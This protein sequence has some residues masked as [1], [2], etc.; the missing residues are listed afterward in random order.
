MSEDIK[1][2]IT[3][4]NIIIIE[5]KKELNWFREYA[6]YI[7]ENHYTVDAEASSYADEDYEN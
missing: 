7:G 5:L 3:D 6:H 2:K 4:L 1:N